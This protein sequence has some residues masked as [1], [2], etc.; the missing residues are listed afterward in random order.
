M[1]VLSRRFGDSIVISENIEVTVLSIK[2]KVVKL[3]IKAPDDIKVVRSELLD[4]LPPNRTVRPTTARVRHTSRT[5]CQKFDGIRISSAQPV[6]C[7]VYN[8]RKKGG[9]YARTRQH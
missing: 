1:L 3:G 8:D 4:P 9:S 7:K 6:G 2:G 5:P